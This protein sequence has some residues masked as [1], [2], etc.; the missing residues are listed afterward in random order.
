MQNLINMKQKIYL[1]FQT[2]N[3]QKTINLLTVNL[4]LHF[5]TD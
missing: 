2:I 3:H 1:N 4:A 5:L